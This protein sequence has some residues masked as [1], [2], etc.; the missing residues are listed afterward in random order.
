M[1]QSQPTTP[2]RT[3]A[4]PFAALRKGLAGQF[5]A[6]PSFHSRIFIPIV[7]ITLISTF[8][9][10]IVGGIVRVTDSGLGCPGWPLC[11]GKVIPP[12]E[13]HAIIEYSHRLLASIVS[14]MVVA[15][16]GMGWVFYKRHKFI[17]FSSLLVAALLILQIALGGLTV[18]AELASEFVTAHLA[19]AETLLAVIG[20]LAVYLMES[21]KSA[22]ASAKMAAFTKLAFV[23][24][25]A[26]FALLMSGSFMVGSNSTAACSGWPLCNGSFIQGQYHQIAAIA[27]R[28]VAAGVGL[29]VLTTAWQGWRM[30]TQSRII[31]VLAVNVIVFFVG[32]VIVGAATVISD[33][34]EFFQSFHLVMASAVWI[35]IVMLT[36][37]AYFTA[38]P[39][40]S[41]LFAELA[42]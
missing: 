28:F 27:H 34:S 30:R 41:E 24:S 35:M 1:N 19:T 38:R 22:V 6:S 11:Y 33:Y 3:V 8:L 12:L 25:L 39:T 32:Q 42:R 21:R 5:S 2:A 31:G 37:S 17:F 26:T 23:T 40:A 20:M 7:L 29:M 14:V 9:L 15:V 16:V 13:K 10:I 4:S 36:A 18:E